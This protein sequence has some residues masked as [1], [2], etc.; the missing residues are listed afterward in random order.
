M[1]A[2]IWSS[3]RSTP[4]LG[5]ASNPTPVNVSSV[6]SHGALAQRRAEQARQNLGAP[7]HEDLLALRGETMVEPRWLLRRVVEVVAER[8]VAGVAMRHLVFDECAHDVPR[9]D[10]GLEEPGD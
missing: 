10:V 9:S 7:L 6:P 4:V 8:F 2:S 3:V 1:Y 5:S